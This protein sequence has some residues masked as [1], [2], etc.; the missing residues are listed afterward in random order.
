[1]ER[2]RAAAGVIDGEHVDPIFA[3]D[4]E[5]AVGEAV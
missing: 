3:D 1:M 5:D 2:T 4:V